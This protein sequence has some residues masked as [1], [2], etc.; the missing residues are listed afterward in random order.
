MKIGKIKEKIIIHTDHQKI[1]KLT[2]YVHGETKGDISVKPT[3]L[4]LGV[5]KKNETTVKTIK[6]DAGKRPLLR[7]LVFLQLSLR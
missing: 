2:V 6:L 4:S 7:F 1:K 5:L 3:Y